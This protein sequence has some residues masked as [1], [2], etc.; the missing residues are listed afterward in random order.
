MSSLWLIQC[1]D[2]KK[3]TTTATGQVFFHVIFHRD[4]SG[5]PRKFME[6]SMGNLMENSAENIHGTSWNSKKFH[7]TPWVQLKVPWKV[8]LNP[9]D[10]PSSVS[11]KRY[12]CISISGSMI[13]PVRQGAEEQHNTRGMHSTIIRRSLDGVWA[14]ADDWNLS[15]L[16][17]ATGSASSRIVSLLGGRYMQYIHSWNRAYDES[18]RSLGKSYGSA[19]VVSFTRASFI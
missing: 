10:S 12:G 4:V 5:V 13:T 3:S 1:E 18:T 17:S 16:A 2:L 11:S 8:P 6:T 14:S 7:G 15:T 9:I 19:G